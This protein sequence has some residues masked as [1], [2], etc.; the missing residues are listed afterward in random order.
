VLDKE[1][2]L[3]GDH[4]DSHKS[5]SFRSPAEFLWHCN[6][7]LKIPSRSQRECPGGHSGR[8]RNRQNLR[9]HR[10]RFCFKDRSNGACPA[11]CPEVGGETVANIRPAVRDAQIRKRAG[12]T[13][14]K[15]WLR[16]GVADPPRQGLA[17]LS[18]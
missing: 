12:T 10:D 14:G 7:E 17:H 3:P 6:N 18:P 8:P 15:A 16:N 9:M 2:A 5:Q 1:S 13:R 4:S 11:E